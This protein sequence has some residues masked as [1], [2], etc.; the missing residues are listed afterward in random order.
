MRRI[1]LLTAAMFLSAS[2][3]WA[4]QGLK[5]KVNLVNALGAKV[6]S[7]EL[8]QTVD[9]VK[10]DLTV[11]GL[12]PGLHGFHIHAVGL[13]EP[14]DFKSAGGHLNPYGRK[15][16]LKNPDGPHAGDMHNLEVGADGTGTAEVLDKLVTLDEGVNS[17]FHEGGTSLVI[18]ADP[19]D[20]MTDPAGNSGARVACGP[21][22]KE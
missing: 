2:L 12:T 20:Q 6:G 11:S 1:P 4:Q 18:H 10:I 5:A 22:V 16:G 8:I 7:A 3:L 14:P 19:D 17:L 21:I 9:G 15:H 13:C